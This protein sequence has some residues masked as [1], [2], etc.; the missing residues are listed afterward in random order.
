MVSG[1]VVSVEG[2]VSS[3][4]AVDSSSGFSGAGLMTPAMTM[5]SSAFRPM[6]KVR[7]AQMATISVHPVTSHCPKA[8]SP[9]AIAVPSMRRPTVWFSPA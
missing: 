9:V 5:V 4:G 8:L 7:P 6:V 2:S 3:E 1:G